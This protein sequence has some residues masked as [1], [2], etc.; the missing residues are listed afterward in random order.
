M[1]PFPLSILSV[2][3][4]LFEGIERLQRLQRLQGVGI[5]GSHNMNRNLKPGFHIFFEGFR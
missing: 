2:S 5:P 3:G 1:Q 4:D